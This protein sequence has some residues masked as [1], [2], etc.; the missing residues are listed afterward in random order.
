MKL[1]MRR[2]LWLALLALV[3]VTAAE[4]M[5]RLDDAV[6]LGTPVLASPSYADLIMHDS[7]GIRGRP[8]ARYEKWTLNGAGFRGREITKFPNPGCIRVAVMGASETFGYYESPGKEYPAQLADSLSRSGCYEVINAAVAGMALPAQIQLWDKWVARFQ[9]SIVVIYVPPVFY[10]AGD[11]PKF[12]SPIQG[13]PDPI[14]T[15]FAPRLLD[16]LHDRIEYPEFI[17]RRRVKRGLANAL[18]GKPESWFYREVPAERLALFRNHLDSLVS[19]IRAR[20]AVPVLVTHAM[21][22][23][24]PPKKE[25]E[26]L[27]SWRKYTPRATEEVLLAFEREAASSTRS[28]ARERGVTLVDVASAMTGHTEWFA[29]FTHFDDKGAGVIAGSIARGVEGLQVSRAA[30]E[31]AVVREYVMSQASGYR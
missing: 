19:S 6:R 18:A 20:G 25:D 26:E 24:D 30:L 28:L 14:P 13:G 22:F 10:L 7:L 16:R 27:L 23:G 17:Q 15:R 1:F 3:V 8:F 12:P 9:P 2:M 4:L 31:P 29:D 11:P 5:A 21:R